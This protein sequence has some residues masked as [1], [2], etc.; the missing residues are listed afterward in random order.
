MPAAVVGIRPVSLGKIRL[1]HPVLHIL[2][3]TEL[4]LVKARSKV[5]TVAV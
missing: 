2:D 1:D 3:A 4:R 5:S